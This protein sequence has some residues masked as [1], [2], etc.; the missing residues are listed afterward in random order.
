MIEWII[1]GLL[2]VVGLVISLVII[3]FFNTW[4]KAFLARAP[5]SFAT[6]LAMR[7]RG[8]PVGMIVDARITAV[9]ASI[10]LETDQLEAHYLAEGNVVQTVQ[11][12]IAA[13]KANIILEWDRA[14]AIDLA[15]RGS[16]K[17]VLE[18]VRTSINPTVIDC[19]IEGRETIDGVAKD[20]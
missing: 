18:A 12:L 8:V 20:G 9:K 13:S 4:L 3:S 19:V 2:L 10:P 5:V 6:L 14:C 11:A 16:S 15:T 7:L 17:S 1:I